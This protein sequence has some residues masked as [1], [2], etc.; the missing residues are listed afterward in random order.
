MIRTETPPLYYDA[1]GYVGM[2]NAGLHTEGVQ[3]FFT[4]TATP[5]LDG[6]YTIFGRVVAGM[7]AVL[8]LRP[9]DAMQMQLK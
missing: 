2:A 9:G 7:D 3:F 1:P 8:A 6:R 5:H 4:H